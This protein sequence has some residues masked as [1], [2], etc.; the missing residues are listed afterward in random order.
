MSCRGCSIAGAR[1]RSG[2]RRA[3]GR[4]FAGHSPIFTVRP[5]AED[6]GDAGHPEAIGARQVVELLRTRHDKP[7]ALVAL[8][9]GRYAVTGPL[10]IVGSASQIQRQAR[11]GLKHASGDAERSWWQEV[12]GALAA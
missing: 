10:M 9:D 8:E 5:W 12:I 3:R 6:D 1:D 2:P 7:G 4:R 11:K